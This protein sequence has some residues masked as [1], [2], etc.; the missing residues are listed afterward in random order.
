[1]NPNELDKF[2]VQALEGYFDSN[3]EFSKIK[4]VQLLLESLLRLRKYIENPK[5]KDINWDNP[6]IELKY[7]VEYQDNE[8]GLPLIFYEENTQEEN[9]EEI[10]L[11]RLFHDVPLSILL[12]A[13][14]DDVV[15][16]KEK[17]KIEA[18]VSTQNEDLKKLTGAKRERYLKELGE[19]HF[20]NNKKPTLALLFKGEFSDDKE[21]KTA[22]GS[23]I[24]DVSP[25]FVDIDSG[26]ANYSVLAG[27]KIEG[28][29]PIYWSKEEKKEF[30]EA[31]KQRT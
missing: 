13:M 1:M 18:R 17:G 2:S 26:E 12:R 15:V 10:I 8:S 23:F 24:L 14:T 5:E 30:W 21:P 3:P 20:S 31:L 28:H 19:K 16:F 25:L 27:L 22:S 4:S 9:T 11:K 29:K 6:C 7:A